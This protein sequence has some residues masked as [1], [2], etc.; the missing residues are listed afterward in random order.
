MHR[1]GKCMASFC[2]DLRYYGTFFHTESKAFLD[3]KGHS[4]RVTGKGHDN[5]IWRIF[6]N[7]F[8]GMKFIWLMK[9][10]IAGIKCSPV[11]VC[12]DGNRSFI[13]IEEFPEIMRFSLELKIFHIFKIVQGDDCFNINR[14]F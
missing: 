9:Y 6:S 11:I 4:R 12:A 7:G 10:D 3:K 1:C 2:N 8:D 13:H 5:Q 14:S